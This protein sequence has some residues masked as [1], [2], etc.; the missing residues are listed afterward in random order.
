M[1]GQII[2]SKREVQS[3]FKVVN[4]ENGSNSDCPQGEPGSPGIRGPSGYN[5]KTGKTGKPGYPGP[6]G[7]KGEQGRQGPPGQDI[8][9]NHTNVENDTVNEY[10]HEYT[11]GYQNLVEMTIKI[12][13]SV[14]KH[15]TAFQMGGAVGID[16]QN[17]S[18]KILIENCTMFSNL[19]KVQSAADFYDCDTCTVGG[20]IYIKAT[21]LSIKLIRSHFINSSI[22]DGSGKYRRFNTGQYISL[23]VIISHSLQFEI[24]T[25]TV[26]SN[27]IAYGTGAIIMLYCPSFD[28]MI[29]GIYVEVSHSRFDRNSVESAAYRYA[30]IQLF[31]EGTKKEDTI[32]FRIVKSVFDQNHMDSPTSNI[33]SLMH[34]IHDD[35]VS[36]NVQHGSSLI[37]ITGSHFKGNIV[38]SVINIQMELV[39]SEIVIHSCKFVNHSL[40]SKYLLQGWCSLS[41]I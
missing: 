19:L 6:P 30:L 38:T 28:D 20:V 14:F 7:P 25:C 27:S 32:H 17:Q 10:L 15:N 1:P 29:K 21:S 23:V 31:T 36:T 16:G 2:R 22:S 4:K 11:V 18:I 3:T 13:G 5:G 37:N 12:I 39:E 41:F 24:M 40:L 35:G 34:S 26:S 8:H 9:I 33:V